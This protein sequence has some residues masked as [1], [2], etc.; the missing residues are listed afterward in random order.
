MIYT[1]GIVL[2]F[3][4]IHFMNFY[5]IKLRMGLQSEYIGRWRT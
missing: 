4:V 1:G 2:V 5:F 3:M